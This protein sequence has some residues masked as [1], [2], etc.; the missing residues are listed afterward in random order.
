MVDIRPDGPS[1]LLHEIPEGEVFVGYRAVEVADRFDVAI[2][3][4][5]RSHY[6]KR[7]PRQ[8]PE[9]RHA[10]I[11]VGISLWKQESI[12]MKLARRHPKLGRF[13]ARLELPHGLGFDYLDPAAERNPQHLSIWGTRADL[14]NAVIDIVPI[15][16]Q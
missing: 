15:D 9:R 2:E 6:E 4:S 1:L 16:P 7:L 5:F 10:A 8:P 12:I 3:Q 14:A 11:Y 13:V